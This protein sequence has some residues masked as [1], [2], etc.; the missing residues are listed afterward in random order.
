M[1]IEILAKIILTV[2]KPAAEET[3]EDFAL[4]AERHLNSLP[5]CIMEKSATQVG[6]RVHIGG[7]AP[8]ILR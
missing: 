7:K 3:P 8:K 1:R 5:L 6:V 2:P 4:A